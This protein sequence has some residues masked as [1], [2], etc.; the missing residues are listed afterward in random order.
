[1]KIE[2]LNETP[3]KFESTWEGVTR[4]RVRQWCVVT[5]KGRPSSF[6]VTVDPG[7]EY[8]PG[9]YELAPESFS[10]NNGRLSVTRVVLSPLAVASIKPQPVASAK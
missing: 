2:V 8:P 3:E 7:K 1:M 9:E 5:I 6:Q 10:F 4:Q